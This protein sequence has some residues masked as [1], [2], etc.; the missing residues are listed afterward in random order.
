MARPRPCAPPVTIKT[1]PVRSKSA[2][3]FLPIVSSTLAGFS[4]GG[5]LVGFFSVSE[6]DEE[7]DALW[8]GEVC[9]ARAQDVAAGLRSCD[10]CEILV[11][12]LG[13]RC[14]VRARMAL[15]V[16]AGFILIV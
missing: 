8:R 11:Q 6:E 9:S 13:R 2:N 14:R 16:A 12:V 5:R 1:L 7:E 4:L 10:C 15:V 3:R